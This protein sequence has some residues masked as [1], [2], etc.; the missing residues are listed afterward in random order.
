M[1]ANTTS[2]YNTSAP[3]NTLIYGGGMDAHEEEARVGW[4][5]PFILL[6]V[7]PMSLII[8]EIIAGNLL[9][10]TSVLTQRHMRTPSNVLIVSLAV[11]DLAVGVFILPFNVA[12][13]ILGWRWGNILCRLW[14]TSD[15]LLSSSS[16]LH[17]CAIA[18][19]RFR[20]VNEGI[21]YVQSRTIRM[22]LVVCGMLWLIALWIA[23]AP[24]LGWN[25]WEPDP[26]S[27]ILVC[28]LARNFG[29]VFHSAVGALIVPTIIMVVIYFRIFF[30]IRT[31]LHDKSK[32]SCVTLHEPMK[33]NN[34]AVELEMLEEVPTEEENDD[35]ASRKFSAEAAK[36]K[37]SKQ[38]E[39]ILVQKIKHS[40]KKERRA[41]KRLGLIIGAF[42]ICWTPFIIVYL[43]NGMVASLLVGKECF[44]E[45]LFQSAS[46]LAYSNSGVNPIIYTM[47]S[48]EF[49]HA[50]MVTL[51]RIFFC[52]KPNVR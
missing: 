6:A 22:A 13:M 41:F 2:K 19:D 24:V 14:L 28:L 10:I 37:H 25:D 5:L 51:K 45:W 48:N 18:V 36:K 27:N 16:V 15:V 11:T 26:D 31:K 50:F 17:I 47:Y 4:T 1:F 12:D 39:E 3:L 21:A 34:E 46:W 52:K 8:L 49:K 44:P 35:Q 38:I 33:K 30:L 7:I 29:Y 32:I 20:S 23:S 43:A 40:M 42:V 9:V